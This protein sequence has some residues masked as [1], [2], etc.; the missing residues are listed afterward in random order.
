MQRT[1]RAIVVS[2]LLAGMDAGAA[3]AHYRAP[4]RLPEMGQLSTM[5]VRKIQAGR[6]SDGGGGPSYPAA[7]SPSAVS[8]G[9]P[10]GTRSIK[11]M[12]FQPIDMAALPGGVGAYIVAPAGDFSPWEQLYVTD[13]TEAGTRLMIEL[14]PAFPDGIFKIHGFVQGS[15]VVETRTARL[16]VSDGTLAGTHEVL[17]GGPVPR[18]D[19]VAVAATQAFAIAYD[20]MGTHLWRF[21]PQPSDTRDLTP[22]VDMDPNSALTSFDDRACFQAGASSIGGQALFCTDGTVAGT[23]A[24]LYDAEGTS[25]G[26]DMSSVFRPS[27]NHLA[28]SAFWQTDPKAEIF[29]SAWATDGTSSGTRRLVSGGVRDQSM[30]GSAIGLSFFSSYQVS[31]GIPVWSSGGTASTTAFLG[32]VPW[33]VEPSPR[34]SLVNPAYGNVVF[35]IGRSLAGTQVMRSD[36]T[37]A[38]TFALPVPEGPVAF[39]PQSDPMMVMLGTRLLVHDL[40]SVWSYD[41]DSLLAASFE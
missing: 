27:G 35:F 1:V 8:D 29:Q 9:T 6:A 21:G 26:I 37:V 34:G 11:N 33:S 36:G 32:H 12:P 39:N 40:E 4:D 13:G 24:I 31:A 14:L 16:V 17:S 23:Q 19:V 18:I 2:A 22:A 15:V 38:G 30:I 10:E 5:T 3:T 41:V 7:F 28:F 25:I 20:A